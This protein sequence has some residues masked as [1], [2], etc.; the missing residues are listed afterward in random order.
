[1][2]GVCRVIMD[3]ANSMGANIFLTQVSIGILSEETGMGWFV[4]DVGHCDLSGM[5]YCSSNQGIYWG[6]Y[7]LKNDPILMVIAS[8]VH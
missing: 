4:P 3:H 2:K 7:D 6:H 1:M 5:S 8:D